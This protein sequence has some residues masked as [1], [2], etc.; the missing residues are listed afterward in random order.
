MFGF[1]GAKIMQ[2]REK[3]DKYISLL[4][5]HPLFRTSLQVLLATWF[6]GTGSIPPG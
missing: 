5:R 3:A 2:N 6:Y 4:N 1:R